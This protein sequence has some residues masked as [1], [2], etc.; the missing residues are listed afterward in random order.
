MIHLLH[1]IFEKQS[2]NQGLTPLG[3]TANGHSVLLFCAEQG[4]LGKEEGAELVITPLLEKP[5]FSKGA[6]K[7]SNKNK[8]KQNKKRILKITDF[9]D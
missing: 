3:L 8:T 4:I 6:L 2:V 5:C 9:V 7:L 1:D